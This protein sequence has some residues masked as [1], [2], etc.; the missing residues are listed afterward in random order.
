[1]CI[2]VKDV[3]TFLRS[4]NT[5]RNQ[6]I[7]SV[8]KIYLIVSTSIAKPGELGVMHAYAFLH[9]KDASVKLLADLLA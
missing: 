1:M 2:L 5:Q 3:V 8:I 4:I 9:Y 7:L 6:T